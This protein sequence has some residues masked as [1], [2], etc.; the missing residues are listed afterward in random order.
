MKQSEKGEEG[1]ERKEEKEEKRGGGKRGRRKREGRRGGGRERGRRREGR[2]RGEERRG[3]ILIEAF[4][5]AAL[6]NASHLF[7]KRTCF[8]F[9]P[10]ELE[11]IGIILNVKIDCFSCN[12]AML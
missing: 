3:G 5:R 9:I 6:W 11:C 12:L 4:L 2:G 1:K 8:S 7:H 10:L